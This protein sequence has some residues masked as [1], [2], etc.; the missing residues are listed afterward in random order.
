MID[1]PTRAK[2]P[3]YDV[4]FFTFASRTDVPVPTA[5]QSAPVMTRFRF[6]NALQIDYVRKS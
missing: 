2:T 5:K 6:D 4:M 1:T 3:S